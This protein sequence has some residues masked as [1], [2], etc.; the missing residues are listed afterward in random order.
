MTEGEEWILRG[1][2][3]VKFVLLIEVTEMARPSKPKDD[4][5]SNWIDFD[6]EQWYDAHEGRMI[7]GSVAGITAQTMDHYADNDSVA[8]CRGQWGEG[9]RG[10]EGK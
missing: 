7:E 4:L 6:P 9:G 5:P 8:G 10:V 1:A 3:I 2:G